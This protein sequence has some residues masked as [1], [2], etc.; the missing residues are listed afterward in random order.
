MIVCGK[1]LQYVQK[2]QKLAYN[3][4][5]KPRNYTLGNKIWFNSKYIKT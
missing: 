4:A 3:K 1:S 5:T 2:L